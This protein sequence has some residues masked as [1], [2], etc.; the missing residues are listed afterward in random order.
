MESATG[1]SF[2]G[3]WALVVLCWAPWILSFWPGTVA[4][5]ATW[6]ITRWVEFIP[7]TNHRPVLAT[8]L[9]GTL[10]DAVG[11]VSSGSLAVTLFQ[12]ASL[13]ASIVY[14]LYALR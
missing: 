8:A 12:R 11:G 10:G 6:Q 3:A 4:W 9:Y 13:S 2:L 5:D 1:R 14:A 7:L